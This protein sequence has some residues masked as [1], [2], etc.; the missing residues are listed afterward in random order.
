MATAGSELHQLTSDYEKNHEIIKA[1]KK[2][3]KVAEENFNTL[4]YILQ[5]SL[6]YN[7][8]SSDTLC[9]F[10]PFHTVL[11]MLVR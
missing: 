8:I 9:N 7:K 6:S 10:S 5:L 1:L 11:S 2:L 4:Y 3:L